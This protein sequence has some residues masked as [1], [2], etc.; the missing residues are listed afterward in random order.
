MSRPPIDLTETICKRIY[1]ALRI[2]ATYEIAALY[3][4]VSYDTL[5]RWRKKGE[6]GEESAVDVVFCELCDTIKKAQAD[7]A[8]SCL[9]KIERA[10][11]DDWKAAAWKLERLFPE[12]YARRI[13]AP[14]VPALPNQNQGNH[15]V[16]P[17]ENTVCHF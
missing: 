4:G 16:S 11:D 1:D 5:L 7:L 2:G 12:Y 6:S 8:M 14:R 13:I 15:E 10:S 9:L 17:S 3:A